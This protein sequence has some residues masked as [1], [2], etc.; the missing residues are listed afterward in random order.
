MEVVLNEEKS[1]FPRFLRRAVLRIV[2][3]MMKLDGG[4]VGDDGDENSKS[5]SGG[6]STY[7]H[8]TEPTHTT[9]HSR[10][11]LEIHYNKGYEYE[12][13]A[14][15]SIGTSNTRRNPSDTMNC[16]SSFLLCLSEP[17]THLKYTA[18]LRGKG[19]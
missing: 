10:K 4:G 9:Q 6:F 5:T 2:D 12:D 1:D 14:K 19:Y 8:Q 3:D 15:T 16:S 13:P 11:P 17:P 7:T 18:I